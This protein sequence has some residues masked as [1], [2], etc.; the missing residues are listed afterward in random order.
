[1]LPKGHLYIYT[2][3]YV[4]MYIPVYMYL[5]VYMCMYMYMLCV[6]WV[7]CVFWKVYCYIT[8]VYEIEP[9]I[10]ILN[11]HEWQRA[12]IPWETI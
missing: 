11:G 8:N 4:C 5:C 12:V 9:E 2:Y 3:A 7:F 10:L 1:M 6:T